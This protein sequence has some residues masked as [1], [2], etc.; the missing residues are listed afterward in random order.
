VG[1]VG[2]EGK[3]RRMNLGEIEIDMVIVWKSQKSIKI[4]WW[5]RRYLL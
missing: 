3:G 4:L 1:F 5:N 2:E